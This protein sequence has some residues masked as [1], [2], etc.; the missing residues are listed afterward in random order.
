VGGEEKSPAITENGSCGQLK[1][2]DRA[3]GNEKQESIVARGKQGKGVYK[4]Y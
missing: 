2:S 4:N 3:R 1:G